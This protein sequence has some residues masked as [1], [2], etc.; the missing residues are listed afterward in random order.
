[1]RILISSL[2]L[3]SVAS[4]VNA[5]D[6]SEAFQ[7][8]KVKGEIK[9][10]YSNSNFLGKTSSDNIWGVGGSLNFVTGDFYGFKAGVTFQAS[11]I[12][13]EDNENNAKLNNELDASGAILSESYLEYAVSNTSFKI[14]RQYIHT[15]LVS[16]AID[17][18]SS[19]SILKDSFE[20]YMITNKDI[21]DTLIQAVYIDKYQAK[22]NS[23]GDI[24]EFNDDKLEDG[25]FSIYVKNSSIENLT[26]QAQYLDVNAKDK[27]NDKNI[28]YIQAD[29]KLGK[30]NLS[31]QYI[32]SEVNSKK[33]QLFG[34][35]AT[36]PLGISNLG[37]ITAISTST[38]DNS[39]NTGIGAGTTDTVLT[40][41]PVHGGDMDVRPNT[42]TIAGGI[43]IPVG[44]GVIIPYYGESLSSE[45]VVGPFKFG[46]VQGA[47]IMAMYSVNKNL[48]LKV[49]FEHIDI[50][51][52]IKEKTDT[53]R[54][55]LKYTF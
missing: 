28:Y 20:A 5:A 15:P 47:G 11:S 16:T 1:M 38:K 49:N 45:G 27:V 34:F 51:R 41:L 42:T 32:S 22:T 10:E 33:G 2:M 36:G 12:L 21:P 19:E 3:V 39:V 44:K 7:E 18:K 40:A 43:V 14:G 53:A 50:E 9:S 25:A 46:N 13:S 23:N 29:Y 54:V 17:G 31:A 35:T 8:A 37:Y 30:H 48:S 4:L 55:Y 24:G 6:L 26:L 52:E